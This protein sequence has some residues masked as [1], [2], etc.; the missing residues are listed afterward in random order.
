MQS[1]PSSRQRR[2]PE[3]GLHSDD[4]IVEMP[5]INIR[6]CAMPYLFVMLLLMAM[7]YTDSPIVTYV[8]WSCGI[9]V[10]VLTL[11]RALNETRRL[12]QHSNLLVSGATRITANELITARRSNPANLR[13]A[14]IDRDFNER[15]YETLLALDEDNVIGVNRG[16]SHSQIN[17]LPTHT[18]HEST[19]VSKGCVICIEAFRR[20][21]VVRTLPCLHQ[22]HAP[23]IDQWLS[24][25]AICPICKHHPLD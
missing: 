16:A 18:Q 13:L 6:A 17:S 10:L 11:Y 25:H 2:D 24:L 15:D 7:M 21:E 19:D 5:T 4:D 22:F 8:I 23:C 9:I 14:L 20:G 12:S 3:I 1:R